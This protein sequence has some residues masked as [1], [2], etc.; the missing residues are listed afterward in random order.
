MTRVEMCKENWKKIGIT[1]VNTLK[2]CIQDIFCRHGHQHEV[3]VAI[4]NL[5]FPDWEDIEKI[6]G[7]HKLTNVYI[8]RI[9]GIE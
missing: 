3:L 5:A 7:S 2:Q 8:D 6:S 9:E 4:Y 1:N